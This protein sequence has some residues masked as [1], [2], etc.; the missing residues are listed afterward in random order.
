MVD[1]FGEIKPKINFSKLKCIRRTLGDCQSCPKKKHF[2]DLKFDPL[3]KLITNPQKFWEI[4]TKMVEI[5]E[6]IK[7]KITSVG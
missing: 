6:G 3:E 5:F 2:T 1:T 7:R 4:C